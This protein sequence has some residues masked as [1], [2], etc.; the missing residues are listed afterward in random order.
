MFICV[1]WYGNWHL[2]RL[3]PLF[4]CARAWSRMLKSASYKYFSWNVSEAFLTVL[5]MSIKAGP[6]IVRYFQKA[7]L[8]VVSANYKL[9]STENKKIVLI[10]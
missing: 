6:W 2:M 9:F 4:V 8:F 1:M 3:K 7:T 10:N 5:K